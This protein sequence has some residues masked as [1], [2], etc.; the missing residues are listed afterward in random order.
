MHDLTNADRASWALDALVPFVV[1]T[2]VDTARDALQ[3]LIGNLLHLAHGRGL[4]VDQ[5]VFG[6]K[7][8]VLEELR[9]DEPGTMDVVQ[10]EFRSLLEADY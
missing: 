10:A 1:Q 7:A 9:E 3:D 8:M 6:A 2:R 5:I 4:D